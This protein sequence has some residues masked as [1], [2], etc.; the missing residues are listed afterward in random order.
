M[1]TNL[2]KRKMQKKLRVLMRKVIN[3]KSDEDPEK[4]IS[5]DVGP[6]KPFRPRRTRLT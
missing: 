6:N 2:L 3:D 4:C 1:P 5:K